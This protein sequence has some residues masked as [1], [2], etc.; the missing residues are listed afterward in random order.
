M[1]LLDEPTS[2][3]DLDGVRKLAAIVRRLAAEGHGHRLC[4]PP[5]ARDPRPCRPRHHPA[6]RHRPRH[7]RDQREPLGKGSDRADGRPLDRGRISAKGH[8]ARRS[9]AAVGHRLLRRQFSRRVVFAARAARSSALPAPKATAS[10]TSSVRLAG[11]RIR[12]ARSS[13]N[14][15]PVRIGR[16][17]DAIDGGLLFLSADRSSESVFP[18]LGVRENM[19]LQ[20]L[21]RFAG[22]GLVSA[23]KEQAEA[24]R[25]VARIRRRHAEP[26]A[27]DQRPV[28]RQPAEIGAGPQFPLRRRGGADRRAD[29]RRRCRRPLRDLSRNPR[30]GSRGQGLRRQ[31]VGCAGTRR[32]LRS[33]AGVFAR[34]HHPRADRRRRDRGK[35]RL[36]VPD[37]PGRPDGR[38]R[39]PSRRRCCTASSRRSL[40]AAANGGSRSASWPR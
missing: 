38:T 4:Q 16:P 12:R 39:E 11:C 36:V 18:E 1:L 17:R 37:G 33:R 26:R 25:L 34:P 19:T 13:C 31:L 30:Q 32:H 35:H 40:P 6:R 2:T 21:D 27:A 20:V 28:R 14:G 10:A 15:K 9:G 7:L 3:L 22:A 8:R 29:A 23:R 24:H 5:P